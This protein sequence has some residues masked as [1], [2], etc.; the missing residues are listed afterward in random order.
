MDHGNLPILF[1]ESSVNRD[2]HR[3]VLDPAK[4]DG[5]VKV[6]Q[7]KAWTVRT[8]LQHMDWF[9]FPISTLK[10]LTLSL[11]NVPGLQKTAVTLVVSPSTSGSISEMLRKY[12]SSLLNF[13]YPDIRSWG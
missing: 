9:F 11:T 10:Y 7:D 6:V 4:K 3:P 8:G 5:M 13:F 2:G 1:Y 12:V